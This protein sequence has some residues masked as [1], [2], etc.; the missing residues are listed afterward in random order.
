MRYQ[1]C[2]LTLVAFLTVVFFFAAAD[3]HTSTSW[4]SGREMLV[5]FA[6]WPSFVAALVVAIISACRV[7]ISHATKFLYP[8]VLSIPMIAYGLYEPG[9]PYDKTAFLR[10]KDRLL[11]DSYAR[12][13]LSRHLLRY[14]E[15][16]A[17]RFRFIGEDDQVQVDGF[18][19][20]VKHLKN[21]GMPSGCTKCWHERD[22]QFLDTFGVSYRYLCDRNRDGYLHWG[23]FKSPVNGKANPWQ[24]QGF[25][26]H[27]AVGLLRQG[28]SVIG[29]WTDYD[30]WVHRGEPW[31]PGL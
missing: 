21:E 9:K 16:H 18:Y 17:E 10:E 15:L 12:G 7:G 23:R 29:I 22:G 6:Y 11:D 14:Y 20:Y 28:D 2:I 30:E 5:F 3:T 25:F 13:L 26:Y 31:G 1:L 27:E 24:E 8:L 19:D 4:A